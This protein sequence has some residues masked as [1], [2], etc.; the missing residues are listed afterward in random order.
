VDY[1]FETRTGSFAQRY[2]GYIVPPIGTKYIQLQMWVASNS[3]VQSSYL[4]DNVKLDEL[5]PFSLNAK[6]EKTVNSEAQDIMSSSPT[7]NG[8]HHYDNEV[9]PV[10]YLELQGNSTYPNSIETNAFAVKENHLYNYSITVKEKNINSN[11]IVA[12]FKNSSDVVK[13]LTRYG[14]NASGGGV[15]SLSPKSAINTSVDILKPSNYTF[16][17]R[18]NT[19]E[20][21]TFLRLGIGGHEMVEGNRF[22]NTSNISLKDKD[23]GLKWVYSNN[24]YLNKGTY[25]IDIYSDSQTDIDSVIVYETGRNVPS[26]NY[27]K[28]HNETVADIFKPDKISTPAYMT[29][30]KKIDPTKYIISI[31][32]A[33]RPYALSFAEGYDPLWIVSTNV[34]D[35]NNTKVSNNFMTSS[36]PLYSVVNGFQINKTG[37]YSLTLEYLP[38]KWFTEAG[39]ISLLALIAM[40]AIYFV[41]THYVQLKKLKRRVW[42]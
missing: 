12:L 3:K 28:K 26:I 24:T 2:N 6:I 7:N 16:A 37:D 14:N 40:S 15:L 31:S 20:T 42:S 11:S 39:T 5:E 33:S 27:N 23:P 19:C 17:I 34:N 10:L 30:Y 36:I 1:P 35:N 29:K 13:N 18:A 9:R 8:D 4:L 22:P 32:N 25:K 21:C 38:Q 41:N